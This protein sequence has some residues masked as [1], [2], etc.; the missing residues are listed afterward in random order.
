MKTI[1]RNH[2]DYNAASKAA[3]LVH[4]IQVYSRGNGVEDDEGHDPGWTINKLTP[5]QRLSLAKVIRRQRKHNRIDR[6][7]SA[8]GL[9]SMFGKIKFGYM[10]K[11]GLRLPNVDDKLT[12]A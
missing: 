6:P 3:K 10:L 9:H 11:A 2:A 1:M 4:Y 7:L 12:P 8:L 5:E